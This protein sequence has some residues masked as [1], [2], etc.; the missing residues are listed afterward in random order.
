MNVFRGIL[1]TVFGIPA[2]IIALSWI[3]HALHHLH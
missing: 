3:A 1:L 2:A